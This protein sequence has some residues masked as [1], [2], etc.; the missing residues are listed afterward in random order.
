MLPY[1]GM[2][3]VN[4]HVLI[5]IFLYGSYLKRKKKIVKKIAKKDF[6]KKFTKSC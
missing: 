5:K 6:F 4:K 1:I 2:G 3:N